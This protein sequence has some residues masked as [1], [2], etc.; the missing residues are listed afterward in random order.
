VHFCLEVVVP[1]NKPSLNVTLS[2]RSEVGD[3]VLAC[4]VC[5][6][7][8][9]ILRPFFIRALRVVD[10]GAL[11]PE[12]TQRQLRPDLRTMKQLLLLWLTSPGEV[13]TC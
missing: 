12:G 10:S 11:E 8:K 1:R 6:V 2:R 3:F 13:Q 9:V 4:G 5:V 7:N